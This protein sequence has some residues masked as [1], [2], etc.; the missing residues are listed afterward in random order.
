MAAERRSARAADLP[1]SGRGWYGRAV[2]PALSLRRN[3]LWTLAGNLTYAACQWGTLAV[4][5]KLGSPEVVGH[6][7]LALA[8]TAPVILFTN[9]NLRA[10]QATDA[11]SEYGFSDYLGLRLAGNAAALAVVAAISLASGYPEATLAVVLVIGLAKAA[12]AFGDVFHGLFQ[13]HE[14]MDLVARSTM[15][16]GLASLLSVALLVA[17]TSELLFAVAALFAAWTLVVLAYDVRAGARLLG[18]WSALRPRLHRPTLSRLARL[19]LPLGVVMT[20][21][22][23]NAS[24]PRYAL[25]RAF[26]AYEV[27]IFSALAYLVVAG[28]TVVNALGQ[29]ATPRLARHFAEGDRRAFLRVLS[30][31]LLAA[32]ALGAGAV[33]VAAL[34]GRPLLTLIYTAEYAGYAPLLVLV[35]FGGALSYAGSAFGYATTA[36]RRFRILVPLFG[37]S[38]A[39][40]ALG[41]AWLIPRFGLAGAAWAVILGTTVQLAGTAVVCFSAL[42]SLA[43][44]GEPE[45]FAETPT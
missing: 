38:T 30:R 19:A 22:S 37:A 18:S 12:E 33:G 15:L 13:R 27:G 16:K 11:R 40:I 2:I 35:L 5:A 7:A 45:A 36:T 14:R 39:V 32:I 10:V 28:S 21:I 44:T 26:S 31:L 29:A 42:W 3:F 23:L 24:I 41:C 4:L 1:V 34:F 6:F 9:L 20:L 17:L 25:E 8:V 43:P